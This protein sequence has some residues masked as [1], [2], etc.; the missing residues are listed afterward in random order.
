[1]GNFDLDLQAAEGEL[2]ED[3]EDEYRIVL[4]V[5]MDRHRQK[6]AYRPSV[7]ESCSSSLSTVN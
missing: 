5:L 1:M 2:D 7:R 3:D 6:S 4:D